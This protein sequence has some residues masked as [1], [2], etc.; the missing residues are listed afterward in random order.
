MFV[1]VVQF[2]PFSHKSSDFSLYPRLSV[3]NLA[4][5]CGMNL[6]KALS[7]SDKLIYRG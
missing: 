6:F 1:F 3:L 2:I 5:L 4:V 7:T